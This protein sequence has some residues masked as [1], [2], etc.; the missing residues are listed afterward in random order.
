MPNDT[1]EHQRLRVELD[2][3]KEKLKNEK[4]PLLKY[5]LVRVLALIVFFQ[6]I[7]TVMGHKI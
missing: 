6:I 2:N 5:V 1:E 4:A 3:L 7:K